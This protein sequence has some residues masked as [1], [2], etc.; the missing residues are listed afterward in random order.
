[1]QVV[2]FHERNFGGVVYPT[3]DGGV[4]TRWEVC[5]D[6]RFA[7]VP[8]EQLVLRRGKGPVAAGP[9]A[10]AVGRYDSEMISS[11]RS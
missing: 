6:R 2:D 8:R 4:V 11:V 7:S 3:H 9:G 10:A 1:M 5:D